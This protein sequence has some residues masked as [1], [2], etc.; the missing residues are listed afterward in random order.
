[1]K[2]AIIITLAAATGTTVGIV[3]HRPWLGGLVSFVIAFGL[4]LIW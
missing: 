1:M 4:Y 2:H 3:F